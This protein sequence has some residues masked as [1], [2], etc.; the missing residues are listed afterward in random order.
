MRIRQMSKGQLIGTVWENST[1]RHRHMIDDA[2]RIDIIGSVGNE[3]VIVRLVNNYH[4]RK[5]TLL[6]IIERVLPGRDGLEYK[7]VP[8]AVP[9]PW[10]RLD[11]GYP[12]TIQDK[13][14]KRF[15]A[16]RVYNHA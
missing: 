10:G 2:T 7:V 5:V 6:L 9:I 13:V 3:F 8:F 11:G 14:L 15:A 16:K 1:A 4:P 12:S